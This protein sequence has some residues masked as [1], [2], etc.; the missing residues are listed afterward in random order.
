MDLPALLRLIR[1]NI[2]GL[3]L[4]TLAG[5]FLGVVYL[6]LAKPQ[7]TA[8]SAIFVD[9]RTRKLVNEDIVQPGYG[10]DVALFESQLNI[11]GSDSIL[12]R[13]VTKLNLVKDVEFVPVGSGSKGL[14]TQWRERIN[15]PR[16][17]ADPVDQALETLAKKIRV[18]RA[19]N[20]YVVNVDVSSDNA[21][22]AAQIANAMLQAYL[23]DQAAAKSDAANKANIMIDSR[24]GELREQ[25]RSAE[26]K[27]DEFKRSNKIVTSEGGMLNEQQLTRLNTELVAV[28][29][30]VATAKARLDEM[31]SVLKRGIS[32]ESLP[33]AMSSP[34]IQR[35]R[36]QLA[37]VARREAALSSQLQ[38]K[39]PVMADIRAQV[40]SI[41]GQI[42]NELQRIT[43]QTQTEYTIAA[44]R[45][46]EIERTLARSEGE[47]AV[48]TTAQIRLR[49][50]EREADA[51]REVLR[52]FLSRAKETQ[53]QKE[54]NVADARVITPSAVPARPSSPNTMLVLALATLGGLGFGVTRAL[55]SSQLSPH[56]VTA[57]TSAGETQKLV[58]DADALA[59]RTIGMIPRLGVKASGQG[60]RRLRAHVPEATT[61]DI[62]S[63]LLED[64]A[65]APVKA[66]RQDVRRVASRIRGLDHDSGQVVL[67]VSAKRD[68]G[69]TF[70]ALAIAFA[71]ALD[72]QRT[73]LI[74]AASADP[75]LSTLFAGD[76]DQDQPCVLDSTEHLNRLIS[77]ETRSGL[78]F[79]PIALADLRTLTM[80][81]RAR[82][83]TGL[84]KLAADYDLVVIDGGATEADTAIAALVP[85]A[86]QVV[87]VAPNGQID[88]AHAQ[89]VAAA[90]QV[91]PERLAG[92]LVAM[93]DATTV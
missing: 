39:H 8:T 3:A 51:S 5:I 49:E 50:L 45:E 14:L 35:L 13:V 26:T 17:V 1:K 18:R 86:S 2:C 34:T 33:E 11:I 57:S 55:I 24:L 58:L 83:A 31:N 82:L 71:H 9:P 15:G 20:T 22:K 76:L 61:E 90:L 85:I 93:G 36:D 92:V 32:P 87:I 27:A 84:N 7:Y 74:D 30:Q 12:R 63:A 78:G 77:R 28:R 23:D 19:Q 29:S 70:S 68:A 37:G 48:T 59:L 46:R 60:L 91:P 80:N 69:T 43:A 79:L 41:R 62:M 56:L 44:G 6:A 89:E 25:V 73:L 4:S 64:N 42:A 75:K 54:L 38:P 67:M 47:V 21:V 81:Q 10:T 53:E 52:A 16:P 40:G 88:D 72:G 66:F 65:D